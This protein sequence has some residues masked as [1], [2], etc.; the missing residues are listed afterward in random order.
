M[1]SKQAILSR[2][3]TIDEKYTVQFFIKKGSHAETYRVKDI[4]GQT[5][6]LKLFQLSKLHRTQFDSEGNIKEVEFLKNIKH[7]NIVQYW[8]SGDWF[9]NNQ[10]FVYLVLDFISGETLAERIK[11]EYTLNPYD[12][13]QIS[14][15]VLNGLKFLHNR[16]QP[17]VHND[18]NHQNIMLDL[19][20]N[21]TVPKIIDFGYARFFKSSTKVYYREGLNPYYLAPECFNNIFSPQSDLF[22]VGALMYHLLFGM[23]PWFVDLSDYQKDRVELEEVL[24]EA[25]NKPLK[26]PTLENRQQKNPEIEKLLP[27]I[28]KALS[29]VTEDR[30]SSADEMLQA[31][32]GDIEV[33]FPQKKTKGYTSQNKTKT[34]KSPVKGNGFSEIAGMD[35]LKETLYHD[36]IR[37]LDEKELYREYGLTI[38]NGMML[39]GPPGCG[40]SFFAEK[41][42][43]EVGYNFEEIKPSSLA[44]IYVHGSQEKIGQL[45][46]KA[47]EN[48]PTILNFEEF[49]ALVPKRDGHAGRNQ[50]G[51][52]NEFLS[53]LNN[54]GKDGV[55]VIA[56][57]NQPNLIDPAVLRAGRIDKVFFVPPPDFKA[58]KEMFR[59]LLESRPLD[60]GINYDLLAEKTENYVSID[61]NHLVDEAARK[62]LRNKSKITEEILLDILSKT[63]PSVKR[64]EIKKYEQIKAQLEGS[65]NNNEPPSIG[66]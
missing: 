21:T 3:E 44:S 59:M 61:I 58:R 2:S 65:G 43:E 37:A 24:L 23:P 26:I 8:D 51:E 16:Q 66:F 25:R 50:S 56:S 13:K 52:V 31:L 41:L 45:F 34:N 60:F 27:I 38:P 11:R 40:K 55:F 19:S 14:S 48:A 28:Q 53:Q 22:S 46:D 5:L 54:C 15:G 7:P 20:G 36:V 47:R 1:K 49:D 12:I 33:D 42:A 62:A 6:F 18:I 29:E 17:I 9:Y 64:A 39:Y 30:F 10:R 32:N 63:R 57:T 35:E 4:D